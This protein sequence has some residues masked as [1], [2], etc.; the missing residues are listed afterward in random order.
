[1]TL[2]P[3]MVSPEDGFQFLAFRLN[4]KK[5]ISVG[6]DV[7]TAVGSVLLYCQE[8]LPVNSKMPLTAF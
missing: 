8:V 2:L 4:L 6:K 1:M 3:K 5:K 7:V